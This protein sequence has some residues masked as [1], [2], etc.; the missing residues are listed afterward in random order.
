MY[1]LQEIKLIVEWYF[2]SFNHI[3]SCGEHLD[4]LPRPH[5]W[6]TCCTRSGE[7]CW[8]T[9]LGAQQWSWESY[10]SLKH[11]EGCVTCMAVSACPKLNQLE[12][13]S[14]SS[15]IKQR[16]KQTKASLKIALQCPVYLHTIVTIVNCYKLVQWTLNT[17]GGL[18]TTIWL[19]TTAPIIGPSNKQ[20]LVFI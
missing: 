1:Y 7:H 11:K 20:Q 16:N 17:G 18:R 4:R 3:G 15:P 19:E 9:A 10:W 5:L 12:K 13:V 6:L 8:E 2:Q 14:E